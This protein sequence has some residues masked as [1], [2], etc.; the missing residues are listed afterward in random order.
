MLHLAKTR[1]NL[2][3]VDDQRGNPTAARDLAEAC[4]SFAIHMAREP[5]AG[6]YGTYHLA[7]VG[8][9]TWY[10]FARAIFEFAR[11]YGSEAA[12]V[13]AIT[14]AEYSTPARRPLD[15]RLNCDATAKDWGIRPQHWSAA[16]EHTLSRLFSQ[17]DFG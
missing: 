6:P 16:L 8:E 1:K 5:D 11:H 2:R 4:L 10:E 7:G 13:R 15:T 3:V 9:T 12:E 17:K 14:T